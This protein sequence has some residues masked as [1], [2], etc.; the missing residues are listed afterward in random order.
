MVFQQPA[1]N[2]LTNLNSK[3]N[4]T[5][6]IRLTTCRRITT[7]TRFKN[8]PLNTNGVGIRL[9]IRVRLVAIQRRRPL[10]SGIAPIRRRR[11]RRP[12]PQDHAVSVRIARGDAVGE[13]Q[14][15]R[16]CATIGAP[17]PPFGV[18]QHARDVDA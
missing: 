12:R 1:K 9:D 6:S 7:T 2:Y 5:R 17:L 14:V 3:I 4:I 10:D 18:G 11:R 15:A 8:T 13:G 16:W